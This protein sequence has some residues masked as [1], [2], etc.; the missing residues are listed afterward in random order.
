MTSLTL[1]PA[2]L[3]R[4]SGQW[5][6]NDFDVL[7]DGKMVG[8]IYEDATAALPTMRWFWSVMRSTTGEGRLGSPRSFNRRCCGRFSSRQLP[9]SPKLMYYPFACVARAPKGGGHERV[10]RALLAAHDFVGGSRAAGVVGDGGPI[11]VDGQC[12]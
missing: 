11:G 3:S 10:A 8:R 2:K 5:S 6:D 1:K 7:A 9:A 4:P 12:A